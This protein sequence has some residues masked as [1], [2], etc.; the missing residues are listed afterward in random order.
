MRILC[1]DAGSSS[2]KYSVFEKSERGERE[3]L[4]QTA[5][6]RAPVAGIF[7]QLEKQ[8]IMPDAVG[9]RIVFGGGHAQPIRATPDVL[10]ELH[11]YVP[12]D[13][14]H[15]PVQLRIVGEIAS[16]A[17]ALPQVLCFDT[18]FHRRMPEIAQRF[19]LPK[20][21]DPLIR[22]YGYHGLSYEYIASQIDW[23]RYDRAVIAHLGNGASLAAVRKGEPVDTT[24]GFT[25]L[26]GLMMGTRPG[27][28]DPG[29]L[30]Y[31]LRSGAFTFETL[32]KLLTEQSGL[33][34][35][36]GSSSD[37]RELLARRQDDAAAELAVQLFSY[38]VAKFAG[39]MAAALGGLD[40]FVFT[41]GI[42]ENAAEVRDMIRARLRMFAG[43]ETLVLPTRE[44]LVI[45][46]HTARTL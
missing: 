44:T 5:D 31:L 12:I 34:G 35:V 39:A 11:G 42:G 26:G 46:R 41:G 28:L 23:K 32:D 15:L 9:H 22:R 33:R 7:A 10:A 45:A 20:N 30:L 43:M 13:P 6:T 8:T 38:S 21:L 14:M 24:M 27:D 17:P 4:S 37:M 16:L 29:V 3:I 40:L 25:P 36:S 18:A 2:L 1:V 19:P